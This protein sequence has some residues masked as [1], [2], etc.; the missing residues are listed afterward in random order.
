MTEAELINYKKEFKSIVYLKGEITNKKNYIKTL[1]A[2]DN[3]DSH[4]KAILSAIKQ[5]NEVVSQ[6]LEKLNGIE[7]NHMMLSLRKATELFKRKDKTKFEQFNPFGKKCIY[8]EK[9]TSGGPYCDD[10]LQQV[11]E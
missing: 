3:A 9:I 7:Y 4:K 2:Y 8:C 11:E 10:H 1:C 5:K 6:F